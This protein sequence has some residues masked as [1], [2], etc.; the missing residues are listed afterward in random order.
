MRRIFCIFAFLVLVLPL[1]ACSSPTVQAAEIHFSFQ[2]KA[3][4]N[5]NGEQFLCNLSRTAPG[6]ASVQ[7]LSGDLDGLS[8]DWDGDGFSI[9]YKD[10]CAKSEDCVL[11]DT[12]FAS[13]LVK[14]LDYAERSDSLTSG[15]DGSFT[16]TFEDK[17]FTITV[18]K[19]TGDI[20]T[21]V[22]PE[23]NLSVKFYNHN[24][25]KRCNV[26]YTF[27]FYIYVIRHR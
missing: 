20:Q 23:T 13:V 19:N 4:V 2:C 22:I 27:L 26:C 18:D 11:P 15:A 24:K 10:L 6:R 25:E 16:G 8:F 9:S 12:A 7:V 3:D 1:A 5:T 21:L 17:D 14:V